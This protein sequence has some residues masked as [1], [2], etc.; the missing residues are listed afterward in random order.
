MR[1]ARYTYE[2]NNPGPTLIKTDH[3]GGLDGTQSVIPMPSGSP[4]AAHK[5]LLDSQCLEDF[6]KYTH[7]P[8]LPDD[9]L[10]YDVTTEL[11]NLD[12]KEQQITTSLM[13]LK[14]GTVGSKTVAMFEGL[15][16]IVSSP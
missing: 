13:E 10:K 3:K 14:Q 15:G 6:L 4:Y 12:T 5:T 16:P 8:V 2:T 11:A 7:F 9:I 1:G